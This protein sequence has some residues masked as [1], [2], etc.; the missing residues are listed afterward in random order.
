M[1]VG[2]KFVTGALLVEVYAT[3]ANSLFCFLLSKHYNAKKGVGVEEENSSQE[4]CWWRFMRH[5]DVS[6]PAFVT[7]SE[8]SGETTDILTTRHSLGPVTV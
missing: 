8:A 5:P 4:L 1:R 3:K 6:I 7:C 2:G